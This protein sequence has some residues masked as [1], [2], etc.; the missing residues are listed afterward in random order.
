MRRG[1]KFPR[2]WHDGESGDF[3]HGKVS[4]GDSPIAGAVRQPQNAPVV[5]DI[6]ITGNRI[7]GDACRRK[8]WETWPSGTIEIRPRRRTRTL[9]IRDGKHMARCC[10]RERAVT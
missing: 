4:A 7:K 10:R 2:T 3:N 1:V 6:E 8:V 9:I 5:R